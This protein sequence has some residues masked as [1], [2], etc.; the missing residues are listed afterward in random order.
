MTC[1]SSGPSAPTDSEALRVNAL[2]GS[3]RQVQAPGSR[4]VFALDSAAAW[5]CPLSVERL[6]VGTQASAVPVTG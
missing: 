1:N 6:G 2:A 3:R 4:R 5:R